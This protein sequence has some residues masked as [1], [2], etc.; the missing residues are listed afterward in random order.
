MRQQMKDSA[1]T[2]KPAEI[3]KL[4]VAAGNFRD[5]C[6]IKS[7]WWFAL[8][9]HELVGLEIPHID[10]DRKRVTVIGKGNKVRVIP[11]IDAEVLS[12]LKIHIGERKKGAVFLS[13]ERK[14]L[15][16]RLVNHIVQ[17]VSE[18]AGVKHPHPER[19][20]VNPH[21]IRHSMARWLKSEGFPQ[22]WV[23]NFL[24]HES[25]K[26]TMDMYG[27]ISIDE[28]QEIAARKLGE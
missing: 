28:M 22:E 18:H 6:I 2:L 21:L 8:R 15:S 3:K 9:R 13:N 1:Y 10:F 17:Q 27:T 7:L 5:R 16:L 23:Q 20:H 19:T 25:I 24:G 11:V 14:A 12:D 26:T 4:I